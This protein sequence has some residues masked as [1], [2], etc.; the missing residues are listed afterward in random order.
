[1]AAHFEHQVQEVA[2]FHAKV[3][4]D[5]CRESVSLPGLPSAGTGE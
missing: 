1:M 5:V 4:A 2:E 3:L